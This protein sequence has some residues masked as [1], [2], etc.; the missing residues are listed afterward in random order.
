MAKGLLQHME[1]LQK[2]IKIP[3]IRNDDASVKKML[4]QLYPKGNKDRLYQDYQRKK[5]KSMGL[6][7]LIGLVSGLY[8]HLSSR[9]EVKLS[10]GAQLI[11]NEW[12]AG[13]YKVVLRANAGE[14]SRKFDMQ[15]S[16]RQYTKEEKEELKKQLCQRLPELIKGENQDLYHVES[17]LA[18]VTSI[19][20]YPFSL[21]WDSEK[22]ERVGRDGKVK[23]EKMTAGGEWV[24]IRAL[25]KDKEAEMDSLELQVFVISK[26]LSPKEEFFE[27]L[28]NALLRLDSTETDKKKIQLPYN[29][30]GIKVDWQEQKADNSIF[31]FLLFLAGSILI[32][33][34]MD[35]DLKKSSKKRNRY[36]LLEYAGFVS[37]L[38]LYLSAGLT[39]RKAFIRM[40]K[41]YAG[42]KGSKGRGYLYEEMK[43]ACHQL[44]NGVAE[45]QVYQQWGQRCG[46]M[47]YR[48]LSFLIASYL[49]QGN[50]QLLQMLA[51]EAD[52]A[53][54][55]R[56]NY[57]RKTG[58]EAGTKLLLPMVM[59]M[60]VVM[61]L[62]LLPVYL[63][64][65][66]I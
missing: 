44:E 39:V 59:M 42:Q 35:Q 10:D 3:G 13:D 61:L 21:S 62:V 38:R 4:K 56:K 9:M 65:G 43:A 57:A 11:R 5:L 36:L 26:N 25:I 32:G 1:K 63:D 48:R 64:F 49:K 12:G 29:L 17:D 55:D 31:I 16:E 51:Q 47:R 58:E 45:E 2:G 20:G 24:T 18:L 53:G 60:I 7:L 8:F 28:E 41:D 33:W 46:E 27:L 15:V 14:W 40:T 23:R 52:S 37:R 30:N 50:D 66:S 6:M 54:E 19:E 34:G 22:P